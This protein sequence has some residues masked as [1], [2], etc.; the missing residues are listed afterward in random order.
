MGAM[1]DDRTGISVIG[2]LARVLL[3]LWCVLAAVGQ[4]RSHDFEF[5]IVYGV[6]FGVH[7]LGHMVVGLAGND[8]LT[9]LAG[10]AFQVLLPIGAAALLWPRRDKYGIAICGCILAYS[11]AQVGVYIA[12]ARAESLDLVS[13]S[14]EGQTHDWNFILERWHLLRQDVA[15]GHFVK[16]I[17]WVVLA[18]SVVLAVLALKALWAP[19]P[20]SDTPPGPPRRAGAA[21]AR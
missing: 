20:Q 16:D 8:V 15:I 21:A 1:T 4:L 2:L 13:L 17:G 14:A 6:L 10:S 7:E 3:L 18:G 11:L 9:A 5:N 12:D 19:P